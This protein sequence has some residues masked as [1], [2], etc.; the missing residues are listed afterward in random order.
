MASR[1]SIKKFS[2]CFSKS[3]GMCRGPMVGHLIVKFGN[4]ESWF[5]VCAGHSPNFLTATLTGQLI[6][7]GL[8]LFGM[9][10]KGAPKFEFRYLRTRG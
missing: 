1:K 6:R 7:K 2:G 3:S 4:Y 10:L 9:P 5:E 8:A